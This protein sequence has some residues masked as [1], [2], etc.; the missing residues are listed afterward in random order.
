LNKKFYGVIVLAMVALVAPRIVQGTFLCGARMQGSLASVLPADVL[1]DPVIE[2]PIRPL[3]PPSSPG[4]SVVAARC[5]PVEAFTL[6]GG[7]AML[8]PLGI[9]RRRNGH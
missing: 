2:E 5:G 3:T 9:L 6:L 4:T 7:L 8:V 1:A